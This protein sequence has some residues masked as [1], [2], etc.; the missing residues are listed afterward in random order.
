MYDQNALKIYTDG[1]AFKNPGGPGGIAGIAEFPEC[2][3]RDNEVIFQKGFDSTTNNRMEL[4]ACLEAL[5]YIGENSKQLNINRAVIITDSDYVYRYHSVAQYWK[6]DQWRNKE[7]RPIE[8][9]DLWDAFLKLWQKTGVRTDVK[10]LKGKTIEVVKKVDK[11]AKKAGR[12]ILK[13]NERYKVGK[14]ARSKVLER[15]AATSFDARGQ[16]ALI[17]IYRK[18]I[19]A[20]DEY[21]IFFNLSLKGKRN[22]IAK[23]YAY[24][25]EDIAI[26]LH[27]SHTYSVLFNSNNKYPI[28]ETIIGE[29]EFKD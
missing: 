17:T 2:L 14:V 13:S 20:K 21:K 16:E 8:N 5:R 23:Y 11:L 26:K 3:D 12:D 9:A 19:V 10:W 25:T 18:R 24:T 15:G 1:C 4:K 6:A 29:Y 28:I 22:Y 7:G 27:R